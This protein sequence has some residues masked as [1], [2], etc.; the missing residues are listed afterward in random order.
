FAVPCP[1]GLIT[2]SS[3]YLPSAI[4]L[5]SVV[6]L[7]TPSL[8]SVAA[9]APGSKIE[10]LDPALDALVAPDAKIEVLGQGMDWVEGPVW[11]KGMGCVMFVDIPKNSIY[12]WKEGEG[13]SIYLRPAGHTEAN[14][15]PE[16]REL[17]CNALTV[18]AQDR[19][20]L[21]DQGK[22]RISRLNETNFVKTI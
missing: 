11:R 17:G 4:L 16:G 2:M 19:L 10:R 7:Q 13:L 21:A 3:K 22:R 12:R 9:D 15:P 1:N 6:F 18:D 20:V 14:P 8:R 5:L